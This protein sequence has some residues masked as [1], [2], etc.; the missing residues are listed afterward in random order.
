LPFG[1]GL[2][3]RYSDLWSMVILYGDVVFFAI[4]AWYFDHIIASNRGRAEP[5][6]FPIKRIIDKFRK[7]N[8]KPAKMI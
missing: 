6:Y 8:N 7:P 2:Y 5:F 1:G 4:L 3:F